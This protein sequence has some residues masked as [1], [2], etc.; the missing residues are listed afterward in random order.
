M[1][2]SLG[3]YGLYYRTPLIAFGVVAGAG[4]MLGDEPIPIDVIRDSP[5]ATNLAVK[6]REAIAGTQ[7]YRQWMTTENAIPTDVIDEFAEAVCLC[8]LDQHEMER[9]AIRAAIFEEDPRPDGQPIELAD[10]GVQQRRLSVAH[11]LT[12]VRDTPAV[13]D[14]E[15]AYRDALWSPANIHGGLHE[16]TAGQWAA[17]IAKDVWQEALCSVWSEFC[18]TGLAL[19]RSTDA[20]LAW[21]EVKELAENL[22]TGHP[23]TL[24]DRLTQ[25]LAANL[26]VTTMPG[27]SDNTVQ[28][29]VTDA[30]LDELRLYTRH[31]DTAA[32]GLI[33]LLELSRRA[34][35]MTGRGWGEALLV[36]SAWQPSM[37]AVFVALDAHLATDPTIGATLWWLVSRFVLPVHENIAYSKLPEFTFRFR[38]EEGLLHFYDTGIG[39]FPLSSIRREPLASLTQDLGFWERLNGIPSLTAYGRRFI[40]DVLG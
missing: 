7:Y 19:T 21:H 9:D 28:V 31:S 35:R 14:A 20:D 30:R 6:M 36:G 33:V 12:L 18:R 3:G 17:L 1:E 5:R 29:N 10:R 34:K 32:S 39:R 16:M 4:T 8:R 15:T 27:A 22:F 38:W 37:A 2:S 13:V 40:Q 26:S 25:N 24:R 23:E 11:Y